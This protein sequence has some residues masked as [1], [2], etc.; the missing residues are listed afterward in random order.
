ME[1]KQGFK[2]ESKTAIVI[3]KE[4]TK[5]QIMSMTMEEK[6]VAIKYYYY[7]IKRIAEEADNVKGT[8]L[9]ETNGGDV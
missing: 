4:L 2:N 9:G 5:E 1:K 8:R 6:L 7:A 3:Q